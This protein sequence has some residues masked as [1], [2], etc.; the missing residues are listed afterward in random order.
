MPVIWETYRLKEIADVQTGPFG[1]QLHKKDYVEVGTPIITVEHLGDNRITYQNLPKVSE[2]DKKRLSKYI[3]REGDVIFSRVGSVDR[4]ALVTKKENNW[5]FSGRC[6]RVRPD[7]KK[8][9]RSISVLFLRE[10][11]F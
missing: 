2:T 1:S 5:L 7:E 4:R 6:L 8:S 10:R 9:K 11:I 3:I